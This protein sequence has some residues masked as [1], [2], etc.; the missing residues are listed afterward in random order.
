MA[1]LALTDLRRGAVVLPEDPAQ[2]PVPITAQPPGR[3]PSQPY[4]VARLPDGRLVFADR[5][6]HRVVAM[7]EDGSNVA[8]F[9]AL[10]AGIGGLRLPGGVAVG[11]DGRIYVADTGNSRIVAVAS[12]AADGWLAYGTKGGPTAGNPAIGR[13]ARPVAVAADAA[14][15]VVADPGA[16]RVVRLSSLDDAGWD[17]TAPGQLHGPVGVALLPGGGIVVADLVARRLAFLAAP[18]AGVTGAVA[19]PLLAGPTAVAAVTDDRLAVCVAPLAAI[20]TVARAG[21]AWSVTLDRALGK[22]GLRRPTALCLLP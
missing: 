16:A 4:G 15:V 19:D 2:A 1:R 7:A 8:S 10:G 3:N 20:V 9:G 14:G 12:M 18:S 13:F 21:G 5:A 6:A 22:D 17:A 11:P